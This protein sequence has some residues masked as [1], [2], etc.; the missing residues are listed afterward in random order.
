M[1]IIIGTRGSKLALAQSELV[2]KLLYKQFIRLSKSQHQNPEITKAVKNGIN[3]SIKKIKTT[4]DILYNKPLAAIG[5]KGLFLKEIEEQLLDGSIDLAVHCL[6]DMPTTLPNGLG[7]TCVLPREEANDVLIS[8]N[9]LLSLANLPYEAKIGTCSVRRKALLLNKRPDLSIIEIRGNIDTRLSK[10]Y[11][12]QVDAIVLA[13]AGLK[14]L[15]LVNLISQ[16]LPIKEFI[17]AP[18]QGAIVIEQRIGNQATTK[19]L[20]IHEIVKKLNHKPTFLTTTAERSC[21]EVLGGNCITP[22]GVY[23]KINTITKKTQIIAVLAESDGSNIYY[24]T[25]KGKVLTTE[26]AIELGK[27]VAFN[28]LEKSNNKTY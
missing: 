22:V 13:K 21:L 10:L 18:G 7:I 4:G 2:S 15:K 14:R 16:N 12:K 23:A 20:I 5:G 11:D 6:K 17:P 19:D 26:N 1:D 25:C 27:K 3:I 24:S 8:H 9:S 28:I